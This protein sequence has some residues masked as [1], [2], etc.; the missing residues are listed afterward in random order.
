MGHGHSH[1]HGH[2]RGSDA[3][4]VR[5][6]T[7]ALVLNGAFLVVELVLGILTGSLALLSDAAHMVSDVAALVLALGAARLATRAADTLRTFGWRRAEVLGAFVN[8]IALVGA[9]AVIFWESGQ[10]L[11]SGSP[12]LS[13]WPVLVGGV[14]GLAINLGSV[15]FLMRAGSDNLNI[16]GALLHM[17]ADAL[18]SV[19]AIVAAIGLWAGYPVADPVAGLLI[20]VLVLY[21]AVALLR[22]SGAVLL[23]FTPPGVDTQALEQ[24]LGQL[25]HVSGVHDLHLWSLD[26]QRPILTAHLVLEEGA[27]SNGG[28]DLIALQDRAHALLRER[29]GVAH[30]TLQ[31]ELGDGCGGC[32]LHQDTDAPA[33]AQAPPPPNE[34]HDHGAH[35]HGGHE[36]GGHDHGH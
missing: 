33:P 30:C 13:P 11:I 15:W 34:P 35:G 32:T 7:W 36:H 3:A 28:L 27:L 18:G 19:G 9:C 12:E 17:L 25:D 24:A 10:R 22:E 14:V 8:G 5:A 16:R 20:A 2:A 31:V 6:L 21:G 26:G 1:T 29:F 4:S 23:Q